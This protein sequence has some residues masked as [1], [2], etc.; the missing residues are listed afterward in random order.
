MTL[1]RT[2]AAAGLAAALASGCDG[3]GVTEP[4][5]PAAPERS[6]VQVP[7]LVFGPESDPDGFVVTLVAEGAGE[8]ASE[9][10][11]ADGG[12]VLFGDLDAGTYSV[13]VTSVDDPCAL[14]GENPRSVTLERGQ[15]VP[16]EFT[17][18]CPADGTA[19]VYARTEG[20]AERYFLDEDGT[21]LLDSGRGGSSGT[22]SLAEGAYHFDFDR[23]SQAGETTATGTLHGDC[24][25]V[26]Y[27][28]VMVIEG[29]EDG[30]FCLLSA[31]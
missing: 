8:L 13:A 21:F 22:Y 15:V 24:M 4:R 28:A 23:T 20:P 1:P 6:A 16:I 9:P 27:S 5:L 19:A 7:L 14:E 18:S 11:E 31:P 26:R 10:V 3:D 30:E 12:T 25:T 17:L 29:S 2:L